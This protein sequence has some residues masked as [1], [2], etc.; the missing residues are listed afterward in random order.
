MSIFTKNLTKDIRK[1]PKCDAHKVGRAHRFN[2][3][4]RLL[5]IVN[6]YPYRCRQF[7]CKFRFYLLGRNA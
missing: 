3:L 4:D 6:V 7:P 5:S 2:K 1:C